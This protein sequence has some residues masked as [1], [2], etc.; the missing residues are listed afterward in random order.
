M[1]RAAS[2]RKKEYAA[3]FT[4][5]KMRMQEKTQKIKLKHVGPLEMDCVENHKDKYETSIYE[6]L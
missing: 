5:K 1:T 4:R 3:K 2:A 6:L